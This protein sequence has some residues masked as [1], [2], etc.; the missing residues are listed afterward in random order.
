[1]FWISAFVCVGLFSSMC[2]SWLRP[3]CVFILRQTPKVPRILSW[4]LWR[5]PCQMSLSR[6]VNWCDHFTLHHTTPHYTTLHRTLHC[7]ALHCAALHYIALHCI[8]L[9]CI[10][11]HCTAPY[12]TTLHYTSVHAPHHTTPR[13]TTLHYT[14]PHHHMTLYYT[15]CTAVHALYY[16]IA[17][18]HTTCTTLRVHCTTTSTT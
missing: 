18:H 3:W 7:I 4:M 14:R 12:Y 9:H 10:A 15:T 5:S 16:T 11:L 8:A 1:M 6:L 17:R 2:E 13:L